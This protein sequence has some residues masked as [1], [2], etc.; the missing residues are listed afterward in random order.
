MEAF[1]V[2]LPSDTIVFHHTNAPGLNAVDANGSEV[3]AVTLPDSTRGEQRHA[4]PRALPDGRVLF[5]I[6]GTEPI[7]EH[8]LDG[9]SAGIVSLDDGEVA[10]LAVAGTPWAYLPGDQLLVWNSG[11]FRAYPFDL[12]SNE[13]TD[14]AHTLQTDLRGGDSCDFLR[15]SNSGTAVC[16]DRSAITSRTLVWVDREGEAEVLGFPPAEYRWPRVSPEGDAIAGFAAGR[17]AIVDA[18]TNAVTEI[19]TAPAGEPT[20][21]PDGSAIVFWATEV[22][23]TSHLWI[24][25]RNASEPARQLTQD[26][27]RRDWPTS[28]SPDGSTVLFYDQSDLWT[29]PIEG[30][31]AS[32]LI[33]HPYSWQRDGVFSPNGD[34]VAYSS[35][36]LGPWEVFIIAADGSGGRTRVSSGGGRGPKWSPDGS[37]LYYVEGRRMMAAEVELQPQLRIGAARELFRGGFWVDPS[38]DQFYDVGPDG[39]FLM[40]EGDD[41]VDIRVVTGLTGA[42]AATGGR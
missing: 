8:W 31:P 18:R 32:R 19:T 9:H 1:A 7:R 20:W 39:R 21:T 16:T 12:A 37:E 5:Q 17:L 15:V 3:W 41:V 25:D 14:A 40:V 30:G 13:A 24:R 26:P 35:D 29:V 33:N 23:G 42:V 22:I 2:W 6:R 38:G 34:F 28:V 11:A 27:S 10:R 36:E 4:V